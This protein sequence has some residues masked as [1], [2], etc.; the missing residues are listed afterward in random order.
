MHPYSVPQLVGRYLEHI[1]NTLSQRE[2]HVSGQ[3]EYIQ[4]LK[5]M[6]RVQTGVAES[7]AG[8]RNYWENH[9]GTFEHVDFG[10]NGQVKTKKIADYYRQVSK[11]H[12]WAQCL[13]NLIRLHTP[14]SILELGTALGVSTTYLAHAAPPTSHIHT[15]EGSPE[16]V[17]LTRPILNELHDNLHQHC[18]DISEILPFVLKE[19]GR[20]DFAFIDANHHKEATIRYVENIMEHAS[21]EVVIVLDDIHWSKGMEEAWDTLALRSEFNGAL[22]LFRIGVLVRT[23]RWSQPISRLLIY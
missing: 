7:I 21:D 15:V 12:R 18:G 6:K 8:V 19:M 20:V 5:R 2:I 3:W 14:G 10:R 16:L 23:K 17:A 11:S 4:R 13:H 22:D 9:A 1:V